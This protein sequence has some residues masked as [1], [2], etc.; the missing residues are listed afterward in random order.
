MLGITGHW[1]SWPMF[2]SFNVLNYKRQKSKIRRQDLWHSRIMVPIGQSTSVEE[3]GET[4]L[5]ARYILD[6]W[7]KYG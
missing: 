1:R 4:I 5:C 7:I 6:D 2:N 3:H